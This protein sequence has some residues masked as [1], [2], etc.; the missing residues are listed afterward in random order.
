[1]AMTVMLFRALLRDPNSFLPDSAEKRREAGILEFMDRSCSGAFSFTKC[2]LARS[3][4][5][6]ANFD[7]LIPS[8]QEN[9]TSAA[10][11]FP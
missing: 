2:R 9:D 7:S 1:M 4:S 6:L 5:Q 8:S 10:K 11:K 3:Q